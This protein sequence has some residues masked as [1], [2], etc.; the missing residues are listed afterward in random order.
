MRHAQLR[1]QAPTEE[2]GGGRGDC[3]VVPSVND[4]CSAKSAPSSRT[5][6]QGRSAMTAEEVEV[7][8]ATTERELASLELRLSGRIG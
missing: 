4:R 8:S 7:I 3:G 1:P 6:W 2:K 5:A